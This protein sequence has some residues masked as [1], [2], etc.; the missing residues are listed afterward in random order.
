MS[1]ISMV[2][3]RD[4]SFQVPE[5]IFWMENKPGPK[6]EFSGSATGFATDWIMQSAKL[7]QA[8]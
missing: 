5:L 4:G 8:C 6:R 2:W 3:I 1:S 7:S